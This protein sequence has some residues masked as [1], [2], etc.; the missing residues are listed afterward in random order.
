MRKCPT[1]SAL[2]F[3]FWHIFFFRFQ[4]DLSTVYKIGHQMSRRQFVAFW[5]GDPIGYS[6]SGRTLSE[7][8]PESDTARR[9]ARRSGS[10]I[11]KRADVLKKVICFGPQSRNNLD[12]MSN[13]FPPAATV[14][15]VEWRWSDTSHWTAHFPPK[16]C[17]AAVGCGSSWDSSAVAAHRCNLQVRE[18]SIF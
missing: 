11:L 9:S 12:E 18:E 3:A 1:Q 6:A 7:L 4:F 15:P 8:D 14:R 13:K 5:C 10:G 17:N 2:W 16:W